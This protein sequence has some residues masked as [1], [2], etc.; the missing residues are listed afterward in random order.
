M[1]SNALPIRPSFGPLL[2]EAKGLDVR[3]SL[4]SPCLKHLFDLWLRNRFDRD[5][6]DQDSIDPLDF[7]PWLPNIMLV[8]VET[9]EGQ[10]YFRVRLNGD[11]HVSIAGQNMTGCRLD[12]IA[13]VR[14]DAGK[15]MDVFRNVVETRA[16]HYWRRKYINP[17]MRWNSYERCLLPFVDERGA[18]SRLMAVAQVLIQE[19]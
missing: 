10:L 7:F 3:D 2:F 6:P 16:P 13:T 5:L 18:V 9:G 1:V 14:N 8:D 4:V 12:E 19:D 17:L 15:V 11:M